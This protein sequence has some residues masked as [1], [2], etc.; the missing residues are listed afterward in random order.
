VT[1]RD[2]LTFIAV[3]ILLMAVGTVAC[4]VPARRA[5]RLDA[6]KALRSE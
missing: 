2:S 5:A 4:A 6:L 3:P 1:P